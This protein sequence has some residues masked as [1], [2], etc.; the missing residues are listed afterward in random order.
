MSK[1]LATFL[2]VAGVVSGQISYASLGNTT[3][4]ADTTTPTATAS[5]TI[6]IVVALPTTTSTS[7]L[8]AAPDSSV[9][10]TSGLSYTTQIFYHCTTPTFSAIRPFVTV[11]N[12]VYVDVCP[13][14][15]TSVTYTITDT[16]G[17]HDE[18]DYTRPTG[19]PSGFTTT[20]KT[21]TACP[22]SPVITCTTP[23]NP[24]GPA[25]ETS[26]PTGA[27]GSSPGSNS[28]NQHSTN[29]QSDSTPSF[30]PGS[31]P[32]S[33]PGSTP[34]SAPG[35][36]PSYLT[37]NSAKPAASSS[38]LGLIMGMSMAVVASLMCIL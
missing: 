24:I 5:S 8:S 11:F 1:Y 26:N 31:T 15:L 22:G 6:A 7:T 25:S 2:V 30:A 23:M 28:Q 18:T 33:A 17:C 27:A 16:C 12:T 32:S 13:T 19:C 3:E 9:T 4:A 35:T 21:C 29:L 14:G 10:D 34:S 20:E 36:K 38:P 37:T